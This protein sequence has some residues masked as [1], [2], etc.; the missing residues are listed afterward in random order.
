MLA[1]SAAVDETIGQLEGRLRAGQVVLD[2]GSS[3]PAHSA[4]HAQA[5]K[6]RGVGWVDAPV[7]GGPEGA[8]A[9]ELAIMVGGLA[10]DIAS[11]QPILD[12]LGGNI[13][14]MG[15]PGAGHSAK[16]VNQIIVCLTIEAVAE[17]LTLAE[18][19]GLS[20]PLVVEALRGGFA[21]SRILQVQ[22]RRMIE[23]AY[24]PGGRVATLRKDLALAKSL[25]EAH[26]LTL[27]NVCA[28]L[29]LS[30][31]LVEAGDAEL[32]ASALHKL[33]IAQLSAGVG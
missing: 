2:M 20:L 10:T 9:G 17:A 25:S 1:H 3:N 21:D 18:A 28:T 27:P 26:G 13:V 8:A 16:V 33:R 24:A 12:S 5:L 15:G 22:G 6:Q 19:E 23:R 31:L 7:S 32:D 11:V 4:Q 14:V 30:D 29:E